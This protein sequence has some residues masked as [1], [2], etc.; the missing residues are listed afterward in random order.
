[1]RTMA[2]T[3]STA[4]R[5]TA[6]RAMPHA[7]RT[8]GP[9]SWSTSADPRATGTLRH[10]NVCR[11]TDVRRAARPTAR[12]LPWAALAV[13]YVLWGSTYLANRFVIASIPPLLGSG[14]RFLTGGALLAVLVLVLAGPRAFRMTR[15]QLDRKSTRLN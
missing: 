3:S 8:G 7:Y 2:S 15:A 5:R 11:V 12:V 10:G 6:A 1:M 14:L 4:A 9:P 13:V